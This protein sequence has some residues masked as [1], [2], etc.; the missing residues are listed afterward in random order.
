MVLL[1]KERLLRSEQ[2]SGDIYDFHFDAF[3]SA[4]PT[5]LMPSQHMLDGNPF[6]DIDPLFSQILPISLNQSVTEVSTGLLQ[7]L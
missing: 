5:D 6:S 1:L 3:A 2:T 4:M 7:G